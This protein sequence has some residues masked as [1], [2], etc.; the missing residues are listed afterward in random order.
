MLNVVFSYCYAQC[1]YAGCRYAECRGA[2]F[3]PSLMFVSEARSLQALPKN[4]H[5]VGGG[6]G[7]GFGG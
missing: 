2:H 1:H 6:V 7:G 5:G 4:A 3:D